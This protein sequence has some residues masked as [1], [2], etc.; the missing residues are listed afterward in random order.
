MAPSFRRVAIIENPG[1]GQPSPRRKAALALALATF[2]RAGVA[3][4]HLLIN[5]PGSGRELARQAIA[6]GCDAVLVCGGDGTV[7]EVLQALVGTPVALGVLPMGT[8][9]ALASDLGLGRSPQSALKKLLEARRVDVPVGR[10]I[11]R[12]AAG[13]EEIRYFT[14]AAGVGAD[15][16]LMA[17]MDPVLKR[18][19]G[20]VLYVLEAFRIWVSHR[21]PLFQVTVEGVDGERRVFQ[22]SQLLTVRVRTFGGA[23]GRL[24]P[25][26]SVQSRNLSAIA[27]KTRSRIKYI[28]FILAVVAARQTFGDQVELFTAQSI[29]CRPLYEP[30]IYAEA[31]GEVLGHLPVRIEITDQTVTLLVPPNVEP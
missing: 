14:V 16:L 7:H 29:E 20:Y 11:G 3:S 21:F 22:A 15:A 13:Q 27:V 25:G 4:E 10:V 23:V 9:N 19:L 5:G 26:A 30:E 17:R 24:A 6:D 18:R 1:S 8:A 31:D 28:R 12:D 2:Q